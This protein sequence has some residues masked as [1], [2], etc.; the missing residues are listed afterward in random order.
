[1]ECLHPAGIREW[2]GTFDSGNRSAD[3]AIESFFTILPDSIDAFRYWRRLL[4]AHAVRGTK[5]HDARLVGIMQAHQV[6]RILTFNADDFNRY[7]VVV[8]IDPA[9][10]IP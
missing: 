1:L 9:S 4:V 3:L 8:T 7:G 6:T 2:F 5:V 10:V